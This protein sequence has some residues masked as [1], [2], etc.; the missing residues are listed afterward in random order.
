MVI[1]PTQ[2]SLPD[3]ASC[4]SEHAIYLCQAG[5]DVRRSSRRVSPPGPG[6]ATPERP[7]MAGSPVGLIEGLGKAEIVLLGLPLYNFGVPSQ[8]RAYFDPVARAGIT[9]R[10]T[11]ASGSCGWLP[12]IRFQAS[13]LVSLK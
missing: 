4:L 13:G 8:L 3:S 7:P 9:F 6:A 1:R 12:Q 5:Y 11:A 10:N 2:Q